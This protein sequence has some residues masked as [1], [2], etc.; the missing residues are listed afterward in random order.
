[1]LTHK[2]REA[3]GTEMKGAAIGGAGRSVEV[4]GSVCSKAGPSRSPPHQIAQHKPHR[5]PEQR[6]QAPNRCHRHFSQ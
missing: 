6:A 2:I 4:D 3:M 5:T 1:M